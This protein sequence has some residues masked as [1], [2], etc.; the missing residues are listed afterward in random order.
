[1]FGMTCLP[2]DAEA[3]DDAGPGGR[4]G[5][6][7]GCECELWMLHESPCLIN[8]ARGPPAVLA[9]ARG[10]VVG[11]GVV[12]GSGSGRGR[13]RGR[14]SV[15]MKMGILQRGGSSLQGGPGDLQPAGRA[16]NRLHA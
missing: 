5:C 2:L 12:F 15:Y 11:G 1:M 8:D 16:R 14:G 10:R 7:S 6:T 13:G 9:W 3:R 4:H